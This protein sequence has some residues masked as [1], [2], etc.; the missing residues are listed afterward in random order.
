MIIVR[1]LALLCALLAVGLALACCARA[2]RNWSA[3][4]PPSARFGTG[5]G[6]S[7][8]DVGV[9]LLPPADG[10]LRLIRNFLALG[11]V[12]INSLR[13]FQG[14]KHMQLPIQQHGC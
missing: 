12:V 5:D 1:T 7:V 13:L 9:S 3:A 6:F 11:F 2:M 14:I 8:D 4:V 10:A